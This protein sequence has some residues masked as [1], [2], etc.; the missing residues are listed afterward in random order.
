M[1]YGTEYSL[2][3]GKNKCIKIDEHFSE[4][5]KTFDYVIELNDK[6]RSVSLSLTQQELETVAETLMLLV[7]MTAVRTSN[8]K[9]K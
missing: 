2:T 5:R 9:L 6:S 7:G 4:R 3:L 8:N 1:G